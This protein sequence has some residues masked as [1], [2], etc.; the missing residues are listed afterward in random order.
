MGIFFV[1]I[2]KSAICLAVFYLFYRLLLS[3][4][5]FHRFNRYALLGLLIISFLLPLV[6]VSVKWPTELGNNLQIL[7]QMILTDDM[8]IEGVVPS[9]PSGMSLGIQL[10]IGVYFL[11]ILFFTGRL[12]YAFFRLLWKLKSCEHEPM[13]NYLSTDTKAVLLTHDDTMAP[14]SWMKF[15]II[16][17]KDLQ[18]NA[19]EI[20]IHELSHIRNHH[21]TDLL[22]ADI[23]ILFQWFN[24]AAW[25]LKQELQNIHEYEA[26]ENV[27]NEGVNVKQYQL[28]LIKKAVGTRLYTMANS[29]NHS[30]LNKRITMMQKQ[31]SSQWARLKYLYVLPVAIVAVSA[32]ARPEVSDK[33]KEI[34]AVKVNDLSANVE[35]IV[36]E[37][38][39]TLLSQSTDSAVSET[40]KAPTLVLS[41]ADE[42]PQY[43]G[44]ISAFMQ[45]IGD[46]MRY[47]KSAKQKGLEGQVVVQFVIDE[48]GNVLDPKVVRSVDE[49]LDAEAIRVVSLSPKWEAG[50]LAG[51]PVAIKYTDPLH[52][53]L[54]IDS[55]VSTESTTTPQKINIMTI[56]ATGGTNTTKMFVNGEEVDPSEL[57]AFN[58]HDIESMQ[59]L[60]SEVELKKYNAEG[61][62]AVILITTKK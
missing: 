18:E 49:E 57:K 22:V 20:L 3:K 29:F 47:P 37:K 40:I 38:S 51:K 35:K 45:Y 16:S 30:K 14:F 48:E 27:I 32:F 13:A 6:K 21:S 24:P 54:D 44:G 1:Y 19:R 15:I 8:M 61:A 28:L 4:E 41:A 56:V 59:V 58:E 10:L 62:D 25:L 12:F 42:M 31:K 2:L 60:K 50:K 7:E 36:S 9:V 23:C 39:S 46:N 53:T 5:T 11:G 33:V 17:R 43:P 26:D 55:E 52:N 34:S